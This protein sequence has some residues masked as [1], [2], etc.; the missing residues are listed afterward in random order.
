MCPK[1]GLQWCLNQKDL[2]G[3]ICASGRLVNE[4]TGITL[5]FMNR[6]EYSE[7]LGHSSLTYNI[8]I[9]PLILSLSLKARGMQ[10]LLMY[11]KLLKQVLKDD[12]LW[13]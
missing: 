12:D 13:G 10:T 1:K 11:D 4:L 9:L 8:G 6:D 3:S 7:Q 2:K 5:K